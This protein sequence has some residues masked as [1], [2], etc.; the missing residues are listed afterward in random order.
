MPFALSYAGGATVYGDFYR[1]FGLSCT[2]STLLSAFLSWHLGQ[3][4]RSTPT[5]AGFMGWAFFILQLPGV[6][7]SFLYFGPPPMV[8]SVVVALILGC[9]A[10]LTSRSRA[11]QVRIKAGALPEARFG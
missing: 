6:V 11:P 3:L 10:R 8:L 9:A 5:A 4:A 2:V 1:G 7:L